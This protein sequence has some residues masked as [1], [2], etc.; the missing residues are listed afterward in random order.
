MPHQNNVNP[1]SAFTLIELLIVITLTFIISIGFYT[2]F[3]TNLFTYLNLQKDATTFTD[4]AWQSQRV[5]NVVRGL[6]DIVSAADEDLVM[7]TYFFPSDTYVSKVHYY[8]GNSGKTLYADVTPMTSNP[9]VGTPITANLKTH[10]IIPEYKQSGGVKLFEYLDT[11]GAP[12]ALPI[13][14]LRM[15]KA[16]RVNLATTTSG[17]TNQAITLSV[18]LRNRKTNL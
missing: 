10:T 11:A 9:P 18:S 8:L 1:Q 5:A 12:M 7:Y 4:I 2:F 17:Q 3:K 15:V 14:D 13:A 6:T 16:I